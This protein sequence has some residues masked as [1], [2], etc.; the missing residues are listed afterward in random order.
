MSGEMDNCIFCK[1]IAD[2]APSEKIYEDD[3]VI[4][5]TDIKPASKHHYLIIPKTHIENAKTMQGPE[6]KNTFEHMVKVLTTISEMKGIDLNDARIGFHWPPFNSVN[7]LHLHVISP[8]GNMGFLGRMMFLPNS[9][10][11]ASIDYVR[12]R[13]QTCS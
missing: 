7:H 13:L 8:V 4:C 11:F 3:V 2:Q 5:I 6:D 12:S 1:I 9:L 10:W